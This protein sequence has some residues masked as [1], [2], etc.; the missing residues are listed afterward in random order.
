MAFIQL[1]LFSNALGMQTQVGVIIPQKDTVGEIGLDNGVQSGKYK[2]LYLLHG[3]S[4]DQTIW[5]R[6]TSIERYAT[7]YG[8]CVVMPFGGRS[9]YMNEKNGDQYYT[10]IAK[11]LPARIGEFFN[12]SNKREDRGIAGNSMGGY[13]ALKIALKESNVFGMGAGLSSV[14]DIRLQRFEQH[15]KNVL[16]EENYISD[17]E[18]LFALATKHN[19]AEVKPRLFMS[20]GTEDFLYQDNVRL[21]EHF[22]TL[23]YDYTY[24]EHPGVHCW[25]YWDEHIQR[26]LKW[27]FGNNV[28]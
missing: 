21:K 10:Y 3:L 25:E 4:D 16:G 27:M 14:A 15:L 13:G 2:T 8:I 9:F 19:N 24:E 22:K 26:V 20:C 6:R 1:H 28:Q 12:V 5:H 17:D 11:E 18:D 7:E 23:D